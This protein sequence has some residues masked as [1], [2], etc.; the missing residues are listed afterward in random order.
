MLVILDNIKRGR[1]S[2]LEVSVFRTK[3]VFLSGIK[4]TP[5]LDSAWNQTQECLPLL[6]FQRLETNKCAAG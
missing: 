1:L 3:A 2:H 6:F 4:T 5:G